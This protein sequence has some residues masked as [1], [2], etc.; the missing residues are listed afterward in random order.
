MHDAEGGF[1]AGS[2]ISAARKRRLA[3]LAQQQGL[4]SADAAGATAQQQG[5]LPNSV[6]G[7]FNASD[8][9]QA[10]FSGSAQQQGLVSCVPGAFSPSGSAEKRG[11]ENGSAER[12]IMQSREDASVDG[13]SRKR[14]KQQAAGAKSSRGGQVRSEA[15][16]EQMNMCVV[17]F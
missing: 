1:D 13:S 14:Q 6:C 8:V 2:G 9:P 12:F 11:M 16:K 10:A 17:G 5:L 15:K 4:I 3:A 7:A